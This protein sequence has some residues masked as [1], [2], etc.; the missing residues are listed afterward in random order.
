MTEKMQAENKALLKTF[1][2][3]LFSYFEHNVQKLQ[4]SRNVKIIHFVA[5]QQPHSCIPNLVNTTQTL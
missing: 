5:A 1:L 4:W 3:S 2:Y